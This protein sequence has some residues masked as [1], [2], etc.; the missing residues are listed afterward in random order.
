MITIKKPY[1]ET[2]NEHTRIVNDLVID[3]E[4]KT[5]WFEVDNEYAKYL[6]TDRADAYLIGILNYAM[7]NKHDIVCEAPVTEELLYNISVILIPAVYSSG[8]NLYKTK[9]TANTLPTIIEGTA[10]GTG[11]SCGVDS[12]SA[13]INHLH[14]AYPG[15]DLTHICINNVGAFNNCYS[16]FG[17]E[18]TRKERY[19]ASEKVAKTLG[20]PLIQTDSN[21]TQAIPMDHLQTHTYSS[22]M[23][24]YMLQKLW[25]TYYYA[26]S[27]RDYTSFSLHDNDLH[28]CSKYEL[29]SLQCFSTSGLRLYSEGGEKTRLKKIEDILDF[30]VAQQNLHV[31]ISKPYNCN[32]CSKCSRTLLM[33]DAL[34]GLEKY[35]KV[36]DIE[37]Y[38]KNTTMYLMWL[39]EQYLRHDEYA[40]EVYDILNE[41]G[42][43]PASLKR[44]VKFNYFFWDKITSHI[45]LTLIKKLVSLKHKL[46]K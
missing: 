25:K 15:M 9:I 16:N 46:F 38:R 6:T 35:S 24:V 31:C 41:R 14:S 11:C 1:L 8:K 45:N 23:A 29:L 27:G 7:R 21:F 22:V 12:F 32:E 42:Q 34:N 39:Y 18:Q 10:I 3:Q 5:I 19:A 40:L 20:L 30:D 37:H 36:F 26:S 43:I 44:K 33:L 13:I 28:E 4:I 17:I 2:K